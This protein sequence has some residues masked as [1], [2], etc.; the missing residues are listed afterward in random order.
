MNDKKKMVRN[1][2]YH[3]MKLKKKKNMEAGK[4]V[5]LEKQQPMLTNIITKTTI[6]M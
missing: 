5:D 1:L 4:M 6:C 2:S 3:L